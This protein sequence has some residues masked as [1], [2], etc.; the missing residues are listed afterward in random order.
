MDTD[1]QIYQDILS[2]FIIQ[3]HFHEIRYTYR[4]TYSMSAPTHIQQ[5]V[6]EWAI[7]PIMA[8]QTMQNYT[9]KHTFRAT[10]EDKDSPSQTYTVNCAKP[11]DLQLFS[12]IP[13]LF[14]L[15][16][17]S[18]VKANNRDSSNERTDNSAAILTGINRSGGLMTFLMRHG[19]W[20]ESKERGRE[21]EDVKKG[22]V[23]LPSNCKANFKRSSQE[24]L[25]E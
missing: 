21:K 16:N 5:S 19:E 22:D 23:A 7:P 1:T 20:E 3:T 12:P 25:Y 2:I 11:H 9:S 18:S 6:A 14:P 24:T 8:E 17:S 13:F 10:L 4:N 15:M